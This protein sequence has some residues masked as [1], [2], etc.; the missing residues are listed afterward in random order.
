MLFS[1]S[2]SARTTRTLLD[3]DDA[4]RAIPSVEYIAQLAEMGTAEMRALLFELRPESLAQ[5][6]LV[7]ALTKQAAAL[8]ARHAI[9]VDAALGDEPNV[10][11][12]VKEALYRIAQEATH[13]TVKHAR[14]SRITLRLACD[15]ERVALEVE[16]NGVGF[17][18]GGAF[19]G[20]LGLVS[21]RERV[22]RLGGTLVIESAPGRG[23]VL[24]IRI[25]HG[26][27]ATP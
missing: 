13:N 3:R 27:G 2:L 14:A 16:D 18:A 21:M 25:P 11:L 23:T 19:P 6:G 20:H 9:E 17:D 7:A 1:I 4:A 8:R 12:E 5:E 26:G 15:A 24:R 10:P 22:E